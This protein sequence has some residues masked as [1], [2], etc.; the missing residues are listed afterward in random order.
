[1]AMV[2]AR[3][4]PLESGSAESKRSTVRD[5]GSSKQHCDGAPA[6]MFGRRVHE[7]K[8]ETI[9]RGACQCLGDNAG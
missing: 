1:M 7:G 6:S 8:N 4:L 5:L 3:N 9:R 2:I